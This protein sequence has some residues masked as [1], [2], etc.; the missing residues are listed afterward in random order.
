MS[1]PPRKL[2]VAKCVGTPEPE[3]VERLEELFALARAGQIAA[4]LDH[5]RFCPACL[6]KRADEAARCPSGH[7][8]RRVPVML[9]VAAVRS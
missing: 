6:S 2:S 3:L 4:P 5:P 9:E 7:P 1:D 8:F